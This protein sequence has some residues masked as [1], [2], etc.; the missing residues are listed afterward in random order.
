MMSFH[1]IRLFSTLIIE[2]PESYF[3]PLG[4]QSSNLLDFKVINLMKATFRIMK[5]LNIEKFKVLIWHQS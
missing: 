2:Q 4:T 1:L 3:K 5:M